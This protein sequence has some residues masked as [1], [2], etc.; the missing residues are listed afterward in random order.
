MIQPV[1]EYIYNT[2]GIIQG[3]VCG[4]L[5]PTS[6]CTLSDPESLEWSIPPSSVPKPPS[7][8]LSKPPVPLLAS[9][10]SQKV[11]RNY[12]RKTK[13]M[14]QCTCSYFLG[15]KYDWSSK[16]SST[17]QCYKYEWSLCIIMSACINETERNSKDRR[18]LKS[19]ISP[20]CTGTP[21]TRK[22]PTQFATNRCAVELIP[23]APFSP[24]TRRA[25]GDLTAI[26]T[27]L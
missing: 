10:K 24:K 9:F 27:Y 18:H 1:I 16:N 22:D 11:L 2:T 5:L 3:N 26:V 25:T 6:G 4:I 23:P 12:L 19:C 13:T 7:N 17:I 8:E 21:N 14:I 15:N 20:M